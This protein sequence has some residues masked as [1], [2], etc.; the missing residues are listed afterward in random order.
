VGR[1]I[2]VIA[3]DGFTKALVK[4]GEPITELPYHNSFGVNC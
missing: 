3:T 2:L 1:N 4:T